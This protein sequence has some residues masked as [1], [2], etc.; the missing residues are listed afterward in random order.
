MTADEFNT[1]QIG[2]VLLNYD[3]LR[4]WTVIDKH[5]QTLIIATTRTLSNPVN[6]DLEGWAII[7]GHSSQIVPPPF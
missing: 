4:N 2:D 7:R 6:S 1:V 3:G 5:G